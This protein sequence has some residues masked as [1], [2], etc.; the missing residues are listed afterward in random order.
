MFMKGTIT[1]LISLIIISALASCGKSKNSSI[2][3]I[4]DDPYTT[5][6]TPS[7]DNRI[8][9]EDETS[10]MELILKI[11]DIEVDVIW[12]DNDSVKALKNLT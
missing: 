10:N 4:S 12:A 6:T 11:D 5:I 1:I 9:K 7:D 3:P 2:Q 8:T